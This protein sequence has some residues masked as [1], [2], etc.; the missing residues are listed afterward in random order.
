MGKQGKMNTNLSTKLGNFIDLMRLQ[1][2]GDQDDQTCY[3][4]LNL[5]RHL[6]RLEN[7]PY[8]FSI[9]SQLSPVLKLQLYLII[10]IQRK[11][12]KRQNVVLSTL[13]YEL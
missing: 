2:F 8:L 12:E 13:F 9:S 4:C 11:Y 7:F 10:V 1:I 5:T 3:K 6:F